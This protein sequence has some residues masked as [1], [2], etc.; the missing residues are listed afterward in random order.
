MSEDVKPKRR[1]RGRGEHSMYQR[2]SDGRWIVEIRDGLKPS[3]KPNIRYLTAKTKKEANARLKQE[4]LRISQGRPDTGKPLTVAAYLTAWLT[5][6][7]KPNKRTTTYESYE[8]L[9]RVHITPRIGQVKLVDL[10]AQAVQ[11]MLAEMIEAGTSPTTAK[12]ARGVLRKALNDALRSDLIWRNVVTLTDMPAQR[13]FYPKPLTASELPRYLVAA[14][15]KRLEALFILLPAI[16]LREG[17]AFGLRWPDIDL[18]NGTLAVRQ[19]I[20]RVG[21]PRRPV[22]VEPKT[23]RSRRPVPLPPQV[24]HA[25]RAHKERQNL[26]RLI[27]GSRWGGPNGEWAGL[28]FCTTIGTPLDPS[29]VMK[30]FREIL[31]DAGLDT[32][33]RVHDLRHT[34]ATMLARLGVHPREAQDIMR[35]AQITTTLAVY[36]ST[37]AEGIRGSM[38]RIGMLFADERE[39]T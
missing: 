30:Q 1:R 2:K 28:V 18:E 20:Q 19:Q 17:E 9:C 26:E 35:H 29:N 22:F 31:R 25:L 16:G 39:E 13:T 24:V 32:D 33:R 38:D 5:D 12:N 27:A 6:T 15:G 3:G 11:R 8:T 34:C 7:V 37:D 36:T 23:E 14:R 21:N 4:L 10:S